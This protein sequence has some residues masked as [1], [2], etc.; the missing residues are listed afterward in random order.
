MS[1]ADMKIS[2]RMRNLSAWAVL[3]FIICFHVLNNYHILTVDRMLPACDTFYNYTYGINFKA[4]LTGKVPFFENFS[5]QDYGLRGLYPPL[6]IFNMVISFILFGESYGMAVFS[7]TF[8]YILLIVF[9]YR[10]MRLYAGS[11]VS[12]LVT[13]YFSFMPG[14]YRFSRILLPDFILSASVVVCV[15]FLLRTTVFN[16]KK[17][18]VFFGFACVLGFMS[19]QSFPLVFLPFVLLKI[20]QLKFQNICIA[21]AIILSLALPWY[22]WNAG[23]NGLP[24]WAFVKDVSSIR[25]ISFVQR[26]VMDFYHHGLGGPVFIT[27]I[28]VCVYYLFCVKRKNTEGFL[29][30]FVISFAIFSFCLNEFAAKYVM[31]FVVSLFVITG[32][33]LDDLWQ[34]EKKN[35]FYILSAVIAVI[36]FYNINVYITT[37]YPKETPYFE[38][39]DDCWG[40]RNV[41]VGMKCATKIDYDISELESILPKEIKTPVNLGVFFTNIESEFIRFLMYEKYRNDVFYDN[42]FLNDP[43]ITLNIPEIMETLDLNYDFVLLKSKDYKRLNYLAHPVKL[44]AEGVLGSFADMLVTLRNTYPLY[45]QITVTINGVNYR[46]DVLKIKE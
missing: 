36:T 39:T 28:I 5:L 33:T 23:A 24:L 40:S 21:G 14:L 16:R 9:F 2:M 31:P 34:K 17:D 12:V 20:K 8:M 6:I 19:K 22:I 45:K 46:I 30:W 11:W 13:A 10:I 44:Y 35:F 3:F 27:S 18:A 15:F 29:A 25:T 41:F 37:S 32:I 42:M 26:Y 38:A 4:L 43:V 7:N 1:F